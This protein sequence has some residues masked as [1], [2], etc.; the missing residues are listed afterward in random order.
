M[1]NHIG[2]GEHGSNHVLAVPILLP[3]AI[4]LISNIAIFFAIGMLDGA[5]IVTYLLL[6]G[7]G[8]AMGIVSSVTFLGCAVL[9]QLFT[10]VLNPSG[11]DVSTAIVGPP[12]HH[13][14]QMLFF[15]S[16]ICTLLATLS[17]FFLERKPP[18]LRCTNNE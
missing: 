12:Q 15:I 18:A 3:R 11:L 13:A 17:L 1:Q 5:F 8:T 14:Y 9:M 16:S 4:S 10:V 2:S 7:R 6:K